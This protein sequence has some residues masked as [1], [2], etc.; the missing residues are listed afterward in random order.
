MAH[1]E[2]VGAD[3]LDKLFRNTKLLSSEISK[4]VKTSVDT[5]K[6]IMLN[7]YRGAMSGSGMSGSVVG[8]TA[9][10][11]TKKN[12]L[13]QYTVSRAVGIHFGS[14]E[15]GGAKAIRYAAIAAMLNY[16]IP[17]HW[18]HYSRPNKFGLKEQW[19]SASKTYS[20]VDPA[21]SA[22]EGPAVAAF[23]AKFNSLVKKYIN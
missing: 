4:I 16:G 8:H 21:A 1:I 3:E 17:D 19:F 14:K 11:P 2:V 7:A 18:V 12:A 10:T 6:P 23:E 13:G 15:K 9:N 20:F 22:A 5:T